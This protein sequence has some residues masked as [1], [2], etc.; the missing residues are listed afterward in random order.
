MSAVLEQAAA[1]RV[2]PVRGLGHGLTLAARNIR[3]VLR[4]PPRWWTRSS[5]RSSSWSC[6]RCSSAARSPATGRAT[7]SRW[8][9]D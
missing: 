2:G 1:V 8:C 5:N 9:P 3:S 4:S 6:S 7:S